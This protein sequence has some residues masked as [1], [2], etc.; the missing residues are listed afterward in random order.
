[1]AR[2]RAEGEAA[3]EPRSRRPNKS[4]RAL[5]EATVELIVQV[6]KELDDEGLDAGPDTI[7]W[8][9]EHHHGLR[10]SRSS[11]ARYLARQGLVTPQPKK[12]PKASYI[13]F[14]AEL[15]NECWQA[16]LHPLPPR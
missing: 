11:I 12:R 4:P 14:Q 9:L 13:R 10:V 2:Y 7:R 5:P 16:R 6:R 8:H 1:V 3:F 15:P